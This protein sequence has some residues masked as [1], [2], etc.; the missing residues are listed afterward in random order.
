[1]KNLCITGN[2]KASV[3]SVA[4]IIE[5]A[6]ISPSRAASLQGGEFSMRD[7]HA[8]V[9]RQLTRIDDGQT[10]PRLGRVWEHLAGEI[11]LANHDQGLW[12]WSST[13]DVYTLDFWREFDAQTI[14]LLVYTAPQDA[15]LHAIQNGSNAI[16]P[17]QAALNDWFQHTQN[18]LRFHLRN[19]GR[20][21]LVQ[22]R[23]FLQ[24]AQQYT[25]SVNQHWQLELTSIP[26][27]HEF[28]ADTYQADETPLACIL[29]E[30]FLQ[31][32]TEALTLHNEVMASLFVAHDDTDPAT[33]SE[34]HTE[35]EDSTGASSSSTHYQA[36]AT[37]L[38]SRQR[39]QAAEA[40]Q[41][42]LSAANT[43]LQEH[44]RQAREDQDKLRAEKDGLLHAHQQQ[45][46][47][48]SDENARLIQEREQHA[49]LAKQHQARIDAQAKAHEDALTQLRQT[50]KDTEG[51]NDLILSHLHETQEELERQL[52]DKQEKDKQLSALKQETDR[53]LTILKQEKETLSAELKQ[54]QAKLQTA[55][56]TLTQEKAALTASSQQ[57]KT[58]NAEKAAL[59]A[60][61]DIQ[62]QNDQSTIAEL[63]R[64]IKDIESENDLILS[65]LHETQEELERQLNR[66]SDTENRLTL[67]HRHVQ[68]MLK[69][70]P[71]YWDFEDFQVNPD[72]QNM[73]GATEWHFKKLYLG[74]QY[75]PELRFITT[76]RQ[77][78]AGVIFLRPDTQSPAPLVRW[79][80]SFANTEALPCVP[81]AGPNLKGNNA[82]LSALGTRDWHMLQTLVQRLITLLDT[83][84]DS[85]LPRT[86][87]AHALRAGLT[88]LKQTL[89]NWPTLMRYDAITL[90]EADSRDGYHCLSLELDNLTMAGQTWPQLHYRL[91]TVDTPNQ[92]FGENPRLE[93]PQSAQH[94]MKQW[95]AET[96]DD[97]GA[98][99]ELRFARPDAMDT[100]VWTRLAAEDQLLI[101]GL[102]SSLPLQ[103]SELQQAHPTAQPW[104]EWRDM[105]NTM[106]TI[107]ATRTRNQTQAA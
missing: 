28:E 103:L 67:Q 94:A 19:P 84:V 54:A 88:R 102:L 93:F 24:H 23:H 33:Q 105:A 5:Q 85:N 80:S 1:M 87:D 107:V 26:A 104:D 53:Q 68:R 14:F 47:A 66:I 34:T 21:L 31:E 72:I 2:V 55:E 60:Q 99:L 59:Q 70:Y 106:R 69:K 11:L 57:M 49:N 17:L 91:A 9:K 73:E 15:L 81:E 36:L 50:L 10:A 35:V 65:H 74:E 18:M 4:H 95:F 45:I 56:K 96:E 101:A 37:Y 90:Q 86:L 16:E 30:A 27:P 83:P 61:L 98:R 71:D 79:P 22:G 42:Q 75:W 7:W 48:L 46:Q 12:Y 13:P 41:E 92:P 20:S 100:R 44:L 25:K 76:L 8:K 89:D 39:L 78:V 3:D 63:R 52:G 32:Q 82:V 51:E 43:E 29:V 58:L 62:N 64:T 6:G 38:L 97:R 77:G 40:Q